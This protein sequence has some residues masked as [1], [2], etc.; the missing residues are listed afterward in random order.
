MPCPPACSQ[1]RLNVNGI[2]WLSAKTTGNVWSCWARDDSHSP[3]NLSVQSSNSRKIFL[4]SFKKRELQRN[5][6]LE[7]LLTSYVTWE[8]QTSGDSRK[9]ASLHLK[10]E[11]ILR[12]FFLD[13]KWDICRFCSWSWWWSQRKELCENRRKK[14]KNAAVRAVEEPH[15]WTHRTKEGINYTETP[16]ESLQSFSDLDSEK[17]TEEDLLLWD[18]MS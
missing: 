9:T 12:S 6:Q 16:T 8:R 1:N 11:S 15:K 17:T 2:D 3:D 7:I 14:I 18:L 13:P 4:Q 10:E 5:V